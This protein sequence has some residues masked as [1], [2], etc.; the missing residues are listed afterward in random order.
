MVTVFNDV[1]G[2][3][4]NTTNLS[5]VEA[6][7]GSILINGGVPSPSTLSGGVDRPNKP[8]QSTIYR[9]GNVDSPLSVALPDDL[10]DPVLKRESTQRVQ[11]QYRIRVTRNDRSRQLQDAAGWVLERRCRSSGHSG[12]SGSRIPVRPG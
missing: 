7:V 12:C 8:S 5:Y 6:T 1:P 10:E 3:V 9:H 2:A 11:I 4:G